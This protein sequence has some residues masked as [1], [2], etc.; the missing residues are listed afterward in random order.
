MMSEEL[1]GKLIA[2][3]YRVGELIREGEAGDLYHARHEVMDRPVLLKVLPLALGIDARWQKRFLDEA[4]AGASVSHPNILQLNDFGIDQKQF[5]YAVFEQ[6]DGETLADRVKEHRLD[7]PV[8]VDLAKG[9]AN[10][11]AAA[12]EKGVIH[13]E[14]SP[15]NVFMLGDQPKVYGIGSDPMTVSRDA[16]PRY[17]APEQL[18]KF[19]A[20]DHRSDI[21][22]LGVT[23]YEMLT[24]A[25][26]FEGQ[27]AAE[28]L[29][30]Q[31]S[32]P[33]PPFSVFRSDLNADIEPIVLSSMA[34]DPERRYQS[35][36]DLAEDLEMLGTRIASPAAA[37]AAAGARPV[38]QT[39]AIVALGVILLAGV[40]I[41]ATRTKQTDITASLKADEGSLPVQPIGPATGA[42][43]DALARLPVD[44]TPEEIAAAQAAGVSAA[45]GAPPA[46]G[47]TGGPLA[48]STAPVPGADTYNPWANG[49]VPPPGAPA[50][51]PPAGARVSGDVNPNSPFTGEGGGGAQI[52]R[53]NVLTGECTD[54]NTGTPVPCPG[55]NDPNARQIAPPKGAAN[56]NT[57]NPKPTPKG[58]PAPS[59]PSANTSAPAKQ[60]SNPPAKPGGDQLQD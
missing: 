52:I 44:M 45:L 26:P 8:S 42:Q 37:A 34:L 48:G 13:G 35:M 51:V 19:A 31:K 54:F 12:H 59:R 46:A 11:L 40:L 47:Y 14:L 21:Y 53:K 50:S 24:G 55:A 9:I 57:A 17:L 28:I 5:C 16:D 39:A 7:E 36:K 29:A 38:W 18:N 2:E 27:N 25:L 1:S 4:R 32:G 41:Y 6:V 58:T 49:G 30:K 33:P 15:R 22:A 23:M 10:A 43:E 20:A 60:P 3:K 56:A